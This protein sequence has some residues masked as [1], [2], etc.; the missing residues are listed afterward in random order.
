MGRRHADALIPVR[1]RVLGGNSTS[2]PLKLDRASQHWVG[3]N[4]DDQS[5]SGSD[6]ANLREEAFDPPCSRS[7]GSAGA[8]FGQPIDRR[9]AGLEAFG[10]VARRPVGHLFMDSRRGSETRIG[11][12]HEPGGHS[13][14]LCSRRCWSRPLNEPE[15]SCTTSALGTRCPWSMRTYG[16]VWYRSIA[17][18][19]CSSW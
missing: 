7:V 2:D 3:R 19:A 6:H 9:E 18:A 14:K 17:A 10:V 4:G 16:G 1:R 5:S 15:R 13:E 12:V 11:A 8:Q